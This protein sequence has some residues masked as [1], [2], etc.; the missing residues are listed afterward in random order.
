LTGKICCGILTILV[1]KIPRSMLFLQTNIPFIDAIATALNIED[2]NKTIQDM[3]V[4]FLISVPLSLLLYLIFS[5]YRHW[6]LIDLGNHKWL[7]K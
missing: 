1:S 5:R 6:M 7:I 4:V 3:Y 2:I